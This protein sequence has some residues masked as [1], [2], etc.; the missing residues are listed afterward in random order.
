M[1]LSIPL[2]IIAFNVTWITTPW[3]YLRQIWIKKVLL[4]LS[5]P[6]RRIPIISVRSKIYDLRVKW[7][8]SLYAYH[9]PSTSPQDDRQYQRMKLQRT[10]AWR[11]KDKEVIDML[12]RYFKPKDINK[13]DD[14]DPQQDKRGVMFDEYLALRLKHLKERRRRKLEMN[15]EK[16]ILG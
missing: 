3:N 2:L 15:W 11:L 7:L 9:F 5:K 6:L 14:Y 4:R 16:G 1:A 12:E 13:D 10:F 8:D